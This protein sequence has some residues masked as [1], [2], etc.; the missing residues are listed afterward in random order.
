MCLVSEARRFVLTGPGCR[1]LPLGVF[2]LLP[3]RRLGLG[4]RAAC[5]NASCT[6]V[7][8]Q[9]VWIYPP[10]HF[11]PVCLSG[12]SGFVG[13]WQNG[14]ALGFGWS[15]FVRCTGSSFNRLGNR[16]WMSLACF[17]SKGLINPK[18][19]LSPCHRL[20]DYRLTAYACPAMTDRA[21]RKT[22]CLSV[23][24]HCRIGYWNYSGVHNRCPVSLQ[25]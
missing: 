14:P 18:P 5:V 8:E 4:R 1:C 19:S 2:R 6:L 9:V 3:R 10:G 21:S 24:R 16:R 12:V 20:Y 22:R 17:V 11:L 23:R 7:A 25:A 13:E 15:V